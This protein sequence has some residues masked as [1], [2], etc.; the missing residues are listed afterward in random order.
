M[1]AAARV[2]REKKLS[3]PE[4]ALAARRPHFQNLGPIQIQSLQRL[5][6]NQAVNSLIVQRL[7]GSAK[8]KVVNYGLTA[9]EVESWRTGGGL[10]EKD[11]DVLL[12]ELSQDDFC[13]A[14]T[15]KASDFKGAEDNDDVLALLMS[16]KR[17]KEAAAQATKPSQP[18]K[19]VVQK[20]V[21]L[22]DRVEQE[23]GVSRSDA[24]AFVNTETNN[25]PTIRSWLDTK[26]QAEMRQVVQLV[27]NKNGTLDAIT[28]LLLVNVGLKGYPAQSVLNWAAS[29]GITETQAALNGTSGDD[30]PTFVGLWLQ[31]GVQ[32]DSAE[33]FKKL[34][35]LQARLE[36][37]DG[38][39][40]VFQQ[41][42]VYAGSHDPPS[43]TGF[44]KY[45]FGGDEVELHTHW[46][47]VTKR[48]VSIHVKEGGD[49]STE[50]NHWG[51]FFGAINQAVLAAHNVATGNLKPRTQ[52]EGGKLSL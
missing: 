8:K 12:R 11:V 9:D 44:L 3:P 51:E 5:I 19:Q 50:I 28:Q 38:V 32:P 1:F 41:D 23:V 15:C 45:N 21:T 14:V 49:K 30:S 10:T 4:G 52:P 29:Y 24:A 48:I 43:R 34:V 36:D 26:P 27:V 16:A 42:V 33:S 25:Q 47:E 46:N 6:G 31:Y 39:L 7:S 13:S 37:K 17:K 20:R 2:R 18:P 40:R 22:R 35:R